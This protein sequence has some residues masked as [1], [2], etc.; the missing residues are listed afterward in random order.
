M[1]TTPRLLLNAFLSRD[2]AELRSIRDNAFTMS[3]NTNGQGTLIAS[4]V[5]G[6][7]FTFSA[8]GLATLTPIQI[9]SLAQQ[10][11]DMKAA[12]L[13]RPVTRTRAWFI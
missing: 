2:V 8:P 10:A 3:A 4:T 9:M 7:S 6:S 13:T 11:L 5:N 12:C 1:Q